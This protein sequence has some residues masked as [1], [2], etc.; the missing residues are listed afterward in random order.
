MKKKKLLQ[1]LTSEICDYIINM[2]DEDIFSIEEVEIDIP[3]KANIYETLI[4]DECGET[5]S[6]H[7]IKDYDKKNLCIP[8]YNNFF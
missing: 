5:T 8:C 7:R 4:C 2:P 6:K 1:K 3:E